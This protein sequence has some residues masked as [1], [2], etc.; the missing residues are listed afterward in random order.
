LA[1]RADVAC[2]D[3][4]PTLVWSRVVTEHCSTA[5][6][7]AELATRTF[8]LDQRIRYGYSKPVTNVRQRLRVV[9]PAVHG[10]QRRRRWH[11]TVREAPAPDPVTF[12]DAFGNVTLDVNVSRVDESIEFILSVEAETVGSGDVKPTVADRR[13]LTSTRLTAPDR[14]IT[15]IASGVSHADIASL[16][17]RVR[18]S[19][20]YEWGV[21]GVRTSAAEALAAGRGVCQD[22]AHIML[23]ACRVAR[24]PARYVSGHL[25]GEGGSHAWVEVLHPNPRQP[26]TWIAE[27]WD[28]THDRPTNANY[29]VVA[30][31]RDYADAAPLSGTYQGA[32]ITNTLAVQKRLGID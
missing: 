28:P 16:C 3:A 2:R 5:A 9:P 20:D 26:G 12:V 18:S 13:Y 30:V 8:V 10:R 6:V 4:S 31:G 22:Y 17:T 21:T 24:L 32:G 14:A 11:L 27:G 15:K 1:A 23:S 29:L 25:A 19:I 7:P